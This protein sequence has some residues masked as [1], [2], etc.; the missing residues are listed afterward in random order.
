MKITYLIICLY[1]TMR[2]H[3]VKFSQ[4]FEVVINVGYLEG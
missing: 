2:F 1:T 3:E 4:C